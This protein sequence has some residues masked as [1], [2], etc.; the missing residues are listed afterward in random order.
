MLTLS[1]PAPVDN[2]AKYSVWHENIVSRIEWRA[3]R[4]DCKDPDVID[5]ATCFAFKYFVEREPPMERI[6]TENGIYDAPQW[7]L[8]S[9]RAAK[10]GW[11]RASRGQ[12]FVCTRPTGYVDAMDRIDPSK[13]YATA[14]VDCAHV[15]IDGTEE[16]DAIIASL[17]CPKLVAVAL[18]LS[19]GYSQVEIADHLE[20]SEATISRRAEAIRLHVS[21]WMAAR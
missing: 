12:Q 10:Y 3:W 17:P 14:I 2:R 4:F 15:Y 9:Y 7:R 6:E 8:H 11:N 21:R 1:P 20:L 16:R 19:V 5:N 18:L 13:V